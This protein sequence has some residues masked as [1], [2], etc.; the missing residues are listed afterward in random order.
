[1]LKNRLSVDVGKRWGGGGKQINTYRQFC[2]YVD[3]KHEHI[4]FHTTT[5]TPNF[6]D[7]YY[8]TTSIELL[9][10]NTTIY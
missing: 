7:I 3:D 6:A 4:I 9:E 10:N 1:M 2:C 5:M 8:N